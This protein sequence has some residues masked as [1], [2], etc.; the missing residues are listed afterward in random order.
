[1]LKCFSL[2]IASAAL[3]TG[4]ATTD[5]GAREAGARPIDKS[6]TEAS[7]WY[8]MDEFEK[9]LKVS[10]KLNTDPALNAYV[11][12][13]GCKVAGDF[14]DDIRIYILEEPSF[15]A[16]MSP[17]GMMLV[18]TGLLLRVENE[19]ELAFVL[20]HEFVHFEENHTLERLG[21]VKNANIYGTILGATIAG[22]GGGS[23]G[24]LGY[25]AAVGSAFSFS[26]EQEAEADLKGLQFLERAGYNIGSAAATW[27]NMLAELEASSKKKKQ[28][29]AAKS[30]SGMFE[31]HPVIRDRIAILRVAAAGGE[32][33]P[34]HAE[35]YRARIRPHMKHWLDAEIVKQDYGASLALIDRLASG[36]QD[37]GLL[38]YARGRTLALRGEAGD[39]EAAIAEYRLAAAQEDAPAE[40]FRALGDNYRAA[41]ESDK[42]AEAFK[43][44][45]AR[46]PDAR[47]RLFV[48]SLIT[49]LEGQD[50]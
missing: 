22:V 18:N 12:A 17:N 32:R 31:T 29:R 10:G 5:Y 43:A 40:A 30:G 9:E 44:Y 38:H 35:A 41:G 6:T 37:L 26:R 16:S 4:C 48:E 13:V 3:L 36:G 23:L 47:D 8:Q 34:T 21:A 49:Q 33:R 27:E 14:C 19:A 28:K 25:L 7:I 45:L 2:L 20:S 24:D 1:M 50:E 42:A 46:L 39:S 11:S 15:N